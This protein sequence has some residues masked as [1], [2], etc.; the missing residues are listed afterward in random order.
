MAEYKAAMARTILYLGAV[1][2]A[3][4]DL[5]PALARNAIIRAFKAHHAGQTLSKPKLSLDLGPG[6]AFQS[7]VAAS[8]ELGLAATKWL[9]MAPTPGP[10]GGANIDALIALNDLATGRLL[11]ILDGNLITGIRTA[12]MS[13][14]AAAALARPESTVIGFVGCGLQARAHLPAM[15]SLLPGLATVL[16]LGR[17][18]ESAKRFG[19]H[20]AGLGFKVELSDDAEALVGASDVVVT[21]VPARQGF[22]PFL[23][24]A[25]I[26]PGGFVAAVDVGRSWLSDG[27]R[28]LDVVAIDDHLQQAENPPIW[29]GFG[30]MGSFDADLAELAA[31]TKPGRTSAG[32]RTMFVFRGFALADLALAACVYDAAAAQGVGSA[33]AR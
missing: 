31:G 23:D 1:E 27:M 25:W 32:Q 8:P 6:H 30:P 2:I 24:P 17:E 20:A 21:S 26:A 33:L 7:M 14:A 19:A 4:L 22:E 9:G 28:A 10:S 3:A 29:P 15:K 11:A 18:R 5:D 16:A 12:A 13:A